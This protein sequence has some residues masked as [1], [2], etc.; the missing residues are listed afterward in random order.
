MAVLY[1]S[2]PQPSIQP[3]SVDSCEQ[4]NFLDASPASNGVISPHHV[5]QPR[6]RVVS[7]P[8]AVVA[9]L[10]PLCR[11]SALLRCPRIFREAENKCDKS[12][13]LPILPR[14]WQRSTNPRIRRPRR[15][16][17]I[18]TR[19]DG[20]DMLSWEELHSGVLGCGNWNGGVRP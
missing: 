6:I 10:L 9:H 3:R 1:T 11:G 19:I 5:F 16:L 4:F 18:Y 7:Y 17:L 12:A 8:R 2:I 15:G 20:R 13:T 14:H